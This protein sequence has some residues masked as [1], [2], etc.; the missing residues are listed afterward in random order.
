MTD[1]TTTEQQPQP[2]QKVCGGTCKETLP[3]D[4]FP[5]NR[6]QTDG[7]HVYCKACTLDQVHAHRARL[8]EYKAAKKKRNLANAPKPEP[9]PKPKPK[10]Q[11]SK[12]ARDAQR[13]LEAVNQGHKTFS[14]IQHETGRTASRI[15]DALALLLS[16][17]LIRID[18]RDG[19]RCY[20][21]ATGQPRREDPHGAQREP[22]P[23]LSFSILR[24]L[25]PHRITSA[26]RA[27]GSE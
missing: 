10:A 15:S 1:T 14:K 13:V 24:G 4:D 20:L 6:A 5:V 16:K 17:N 22:A 12:Q 21:P 11:I 2:G 23:A 25:M 27:L 19:A 18:Y 3:L 26:T 9:K 7:H 8:R